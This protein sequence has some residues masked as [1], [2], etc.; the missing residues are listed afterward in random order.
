MAAH[1]DLNAISFFWKDSGNKEFNK[2][3]NAIKYLKE[4]KKFSGTKIYRTTNMYMM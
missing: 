3:K 1:G 4:M 2:A